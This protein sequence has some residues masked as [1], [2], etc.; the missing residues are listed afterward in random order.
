MEVVEGQDVFG[1]PHELAFSTLRD[2]WPNKECNWLPTLAGGFMMA[3]RM[4]GLGPEI[5]N[6][7]YIMPPVIRVR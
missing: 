3:L 2:G 7:Q 4:Y 6:G 5:L 1:E